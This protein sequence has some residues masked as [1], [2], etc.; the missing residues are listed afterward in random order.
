[1]AVLRKLRTPFTKLAGGSLRDLA[2]QMV[3]M[4]P[5]YDTI[6]GLSNSPNTEFHAIH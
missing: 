6:P 2:W 5:V 3:V 1:M 4:M